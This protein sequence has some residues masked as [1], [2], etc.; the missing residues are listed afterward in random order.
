MK[1]L[2]HR[3]KL[4]KRIERKRERKRRIEVFGLVWVELKEAQE[5]KKHNILNPI[6]KEKEHLV[7]IEEREKTFRY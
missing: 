3:D 7:E 2:R 4:W 5:R 1:R 6:L